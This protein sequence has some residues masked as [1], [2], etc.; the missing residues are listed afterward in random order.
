MGKHGYLV[1]LQHGVSSLGKVTENSHKNLQ[2]VNFKSGFYM[3]QSVSG[4]GET[5]PAFWLVTRADEMGLSCPLGISRVGLARK[6]SLFAHIIN[7]LLTKLVPSRWLSWPH[8]W[9]TSH[10]YCAWE[11][12]QRQPT[13]DAG[14]VTFMNKWCLQLAQWS[15][16]LFFRSLLDNACLAY[17]LCHLL[18]PEIKLHTLSVRGVMNHYTRVLQTK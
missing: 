7:P 10:T 18:P 9:S 17:Y 16:I 3:A 12:Y 14:P 11:P 1:L 4:Q 6:S 2:E 5:N 15:I 13:L 8:A